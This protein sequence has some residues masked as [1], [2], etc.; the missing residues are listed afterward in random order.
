VREP[1]VPL[2]KFV[3]FKKTFTSFELFLSGTGSGSAEER[4]GGCGEAEA[5]ASVKDGGVTE[6]GA[7]AGPPHLTVNQ[8]ARLVWRMSRECQAMLDS[9]ETG[10]GR[11]RKLRSGR[12]K[13][14]FLEKGQLRSHIRM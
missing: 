5:Q 4:W 9:R 7:E 11:R 3:F 10:Q 12:N 8:R 2:R 14:L 6:G 1:K 13:L